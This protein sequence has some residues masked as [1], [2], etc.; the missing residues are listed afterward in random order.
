[1]I[2]GYKKAAYNKL[3]ILEIPEDAKTNLHRKNVVKPQFAKY[4]A[5]KA[6]V[7]EI[8]DLTTGQRVETAYSINVNDFIYRSG[9]IVSPTDPFDENLEE[10]CSSGIHFYLDREV[11]EFYEKHTPRN[12]EC[13]NWHDNGLF[14]RHSFMKEGKK[15]GEFKAYSDKVDGLMIFTEN[16]F[17][18]KKHGVSKTFFDT[19][20]TPCEESTYENDKLNGKYLRWYPSGQIQIDC[21]YIKGKL[22]GEY[23]QWYEDG[24]LRFKNIYNNHNREGEA[25]EWHPNGQLARQMFFKDDFRVGTEKI[26]DKEGR[27]VREWSW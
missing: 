20:G 2:V 16:Y 7:R 27:L 24:K 14:E 19:T 15:H 22:D 11:A 23:R 21:Y 25:L 18:G 3:V 10:V 8:I 26:W 17:E 4:R 9:K 6:L 1:M 5:S 12:G 13:K